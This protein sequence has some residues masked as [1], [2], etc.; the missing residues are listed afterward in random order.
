MRPSHRPGPPVALG[1]GDK[2]SAPRPGW[3][4]VEGLWWRIE[5]ALA[6][7]G[8]TGLRPA[9]VGGRRRESR[10]GAGGGRHCPHPH[11]RGRRGPEVCLA[12]RQGPSR[13]CLEQPSPT[14]RAAAGASGLGAAPWRARL[15]RAT[16]Q[17]LGVRG[18]RAQRLGPAPAPRGLVWQPRATRP[19][20]GPR[21]PS[22]AARA[23]RPGHVPSSQLGW[24]A[25]SGAEPGALPIPLQVSGGAADSQVHP[26]NVSFRPGTPSLH[27]YR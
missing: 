18:P 15:C 6:L 17:E 7:P 5:V 20:G 11:P 25:S 10:E 8:V 13:P 12:P 23:V 1:P 9:P 4:G 24:V 22:P 2:V 21:S 27:P 19:S 16:G 26:G 3:G 14:G